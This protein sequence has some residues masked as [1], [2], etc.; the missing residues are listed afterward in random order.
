LRRTADAAGFGHLDD[1]RCL[2]DSNAKGA[3]VRMEAQGPLDIGGPPDESDPGVEV[4][5]RRYCS[6]DD[7][8]G[9]WSPPI[10]STAIRIRSVLPSYS[11]STALTGREL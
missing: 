10:A 5:R 6:V 4:A 7:D 8:R 2:Y 9:A 11:S 1:L 3:P